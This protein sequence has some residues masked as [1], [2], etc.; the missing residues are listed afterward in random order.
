MEENAPKTE[1][2]LLKEADRLAAEVEA[3]IAKGS[4]DETDI[5][6]MGEIP[7]LTPE[8]MEKMDPVQLQAFLAQLAEQRAKF[9]RKPQAFYTRKQTTKAGRKKKRVA[10]KKAR[11]IS[12]INGSGKS[13]PHVQRRKN[14]A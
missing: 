6:D 2:E 7:E 1:E 11:R 10:Q 4:F 9:Q 13:I 12:T 8:M 14:A 3:D 5:G